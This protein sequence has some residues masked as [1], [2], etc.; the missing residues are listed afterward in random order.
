[1]REPEVRERTTLRAGSRRS[2]LGPASVVL[3]SAGSR[4]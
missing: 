3:A 2:G 1:V 4:V